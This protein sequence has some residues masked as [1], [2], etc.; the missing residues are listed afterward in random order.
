M[1]KWQPCSWI[2]MSCQQQGECVPVSVFMHS[3]RTR[4][5]AYGCAR[6]C[7]REQA[8]RGS[9]SQVKGRTRAWCL[10]RGRLDAQIQ[11]MEL[12]LAQLRARD[13]LSRNQLDYNLATAAV[14]TAETAAA[15]TL[16]KRRLTRLHDALHSTKVRAL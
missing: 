1:P 5:P 16:Q 3:S 15:I 13:Q 14:R 10:R 6:H 11:G 9:I 8:G 4:T 2:W 12:S 7:Q